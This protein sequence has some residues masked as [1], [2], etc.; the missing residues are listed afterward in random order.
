MEG[1]ESPYVNVVAVRAGDENSP[2]IQAL[3]NA[4]FSDTVK[5]YVAERYPNG[6][7]ILVD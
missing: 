5:E 7:V 4:L 3:V 1:A 2:K 6:E